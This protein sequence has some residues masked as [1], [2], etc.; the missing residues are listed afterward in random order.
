MLTLCASAGLALMGSW[1]RRRDVR[2]WTWYSNDGFTRKEI[3]HIIVR[4]RDRGIVKSY[5]VFRGS[6]APANTDHRLVV[7]S[8]K[9]C[10]PYS[11]RSQAE[12][13]RVNVDRLRTD[14]FLA[15]KYSADIQNRFDALGTMVGD[16]VESTWRKLSGAITDASI[17]TVGYRRSIKQ[18]WMTDATFDV[19]R[20]KGEA[21]IGGDVP[22]RRRLKG[23]FRAMA[24][25][26]RE[27]FIN[28]LADEAEEGLRHNNLRPA[29]RSIKLL[30]GRGGS[31]E[32]APVQKL[33]GSACDSPT[34]ILNRWKEHYQSVLNFQPAVASPEIANL[35]AITPPDPTVSSDP[36]SLDEVRR[37]I[38]KLKSG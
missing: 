31:L 27:A 25:A 23:I 35:A 8:I 29:Y 19:L 2:R 28:R 36:P 37:A 11:R 18:P 38:Q 12:F 33:D 3:D 24:K 22:E 5:R 1:F 13:R 6:E 14:A 30:A 26:D 10:L 17:G 7:A 34:E 16:D 32:P 21:R 20:R 15:M 9:L 4:Q